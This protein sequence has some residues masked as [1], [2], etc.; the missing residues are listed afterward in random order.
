MKDIVQLIE[1]DLAQ[2][3]QRFE[4]QVKSDVRM[5]GEIG[6]YIREGGGKRIRPA[7][8]LLACRLCGYRGER[9]I[10]LASVVEFIHTATLLHDDII[11]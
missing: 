4:E 10:T 3:E 2:V 1:D 5:V 11:D 9:A 6:R 8:L 7:L